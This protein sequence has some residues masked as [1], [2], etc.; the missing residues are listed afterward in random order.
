MNIKRKL[1][2]AKQSIDSIG[3]HADMDSLVRKSAFDALR[4][5]LDDWI[6]LTDAYNA[7]LID[8]QMPDAENDS[9]GQ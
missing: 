7:R 4:K 9:T 8:S 6:I 2:I 1:E 5:H 3:S